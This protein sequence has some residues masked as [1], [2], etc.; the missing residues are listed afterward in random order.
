MGSVITS[1]KGLLKLV[2]GQINVEVDGSNQPAKDG[3]QL[4][5][6]AVLHIGENATYEITFDDGTKLSNEAVP[7][8]TA[9]VA[10]N[11]T[12]GAALAEIQALQDLIAS[13]ED[14]TQNLPET[15][16]GNTPGRDGNS[17]YVTL[18]R[19]GSEV[20]ATSG[21]STA[22]QSLTATSANTPAQT[23]AIDSPSVVVNDSN[24]IDEDTVATGNVLDN[25]SDVDSILS[26]V[27]FEVD[28]TTY[29]AGTEVALEGGTLVINTDGS[30]TFTP[31]ENWNGNVPVTTYT[32]NTGSSATLSIEVIPAGAAPEV[33]IAADQDS[34]TE[35]QTA[36]FTVSI[37]QVADEDVV[38]S[39]TYSGVAED[40]T[41]FTGV[42]SVIIPAGSTS[43]ALDI[44]T[45]N[46]GIYEGAE[47]FTVTITGVTGADATIGSNDSA[48]TTILDAQSAPEVS[49]AADQDSVTE[50]QTAGFTVSIDQVADE[51]V[52]VSFTY[53]GVAEDGTD[54]TGV[55]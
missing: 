14:P 51:D 9:T 48:D 2:K 13:G 11:T 20:L 36:G 32:T 45:L 38:V 50:G 55:A 47:A 41:D 53:S 4:P 15:A 34:V 39:F 18:A 1:K 22:G 29:A 21:Y 35:G 5:K 23:L 43:V 37:D 30:Y 8:E 40:G 26:V 52:V 24:T 33:S 54:F 28:G 17:G 42:A 10:T 27:S 44:T 46:D 25:D 12:D 6:G 7:N 31:N 3:E 16:A 19:S 49:I